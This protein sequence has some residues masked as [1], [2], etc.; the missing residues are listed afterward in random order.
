MNRGPYTGH[1]ALWWTALAGGILAVGWTTLQGVARSTWFVER[2]HEAVVGGI[3]A[4]TGGH[5]SIRELLLEEPLAFHVKGLEVR[6]GNHPDRPPLLQVPEASVRLGW[7]TVLGGQTVI[8]ELILDGLVLDVAV[9]PSDAPEPGLPLDGPDIASVIVRR[10][11]L[12]QGQVVWNGQPLPAEFAAS[13]LAVEV[14]FDPL[15]QLYTIELSLKDP[16]LGPQD[17]ALPPLGYAS[18]LARVGPDSAEIPEL[19]IRGRTVEVFAS[20]VIPDLQAPVAACSYSLRTTARALAGWL[21]LDLPAVAGS[22]Q[23]DGDLTW[24]FGTGGLTHMGAVVGDRLTLGWEGDPASFEARFEGDGSEFSLD[25][26]QGSLFGGRAE[27][28]GQLRGGWTSR[29]VAAEGRLEGVDLLRSATALGLGTVPWEGLVDAT[30]RLNGS[31][32]AGVTTDLDLAFRPLEE[33]TSSDPPLTGGGTLRHA[34]RDGSVTVEHLRIGSSAAMIEASG[35]VAGDGYAELE[36]QVDIGSRA[37]LEDLFGSLYPTARL[38]TLTP[39]GSYRYRGRMVGP[40]AEESRTS[41]VGELTVEDFLLGGERWESMWARGI[42]SARGLRIRDGFLAGG[43]G[44]LDV[45]GFF[46][47]DPDETMAVSATTVRMSAGKLARAGGFDLPIDGSLSMDLELSG[48]LARPVAEASVVLDD[49][50]FF[51]EQF[52][53]MD[54]EVA[55]GVDGWELRDG[56]LSRGESEILASAAA[57]VGERAIELHLRSEHWPIA[58]VGSLQEFAPGLEGDSSFELEGRGQVGESG[59]LGTLDL[60][61][62]WSIRDLHRDGIS[63]GHWEGRLHSARSRETL[64]LDLDAEVFGGTLRGQASLWQTEPP[65]YSGILQFRDLGVQDMGEFLGMPAADVG[66]RLGGQAEFDGVLGRAGGPN[67]DGTVDQFEVSVLRGDGNVLALSSPRPMRWGVRDGT[68]TLQSMQLAGQGADLS[69]KG[70][71]GLVGERG[72]DVSALGQLDTG[73]IERLVPGVSLDGL[74]TFALH[75]GNSLDEPAFQGSVEL[76]GITA[77]GSGLPVRLGDLRGKVEV[78]GRQARFEQLSA[79]SGGGS[80][81]LSGAAAYH[82]GELEYRLATRLEGVRLNIPAD[83][84]S[85]VDGQLTLAGAGDRS[86]LDGKLMI[87]RLS[88]PASI[89]FADFLQNL[90]RVRS[91]PAELGPLE[92]MQ[93][94]V[95][96]N[97]PPQLAVDTPLV[98]GAR[99]ILDL[100]VVGTASHPSVT[101]SIGIPSGEIRMLGTHYTITRGEIRFVNPLHTESVIDVELET[102]IRDVDIALVLSGPAQDLNVS[103]RSDPPLPFHDLVSLVAVG[104]EPTYDPS[105]ATQRRLEQHS[106]ERTGADALLSQALERPVSRRLQ[107]FFGVSRVKVD[108]QIGGLEANPGARISTEQQITDDITLIYSYDLSSAQQQAV[109]IEWNPN[110][111]WSFIVT[112]DQNGLVGSDVLFKVRLP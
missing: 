72:L 31:L 70:T 68:L 81:E 74:A 37:A 82:N 46:P 58:A 1:A 23:A 33:P 27:V 96:V 15:E 75:A 52:D 48:S 63:L 51:Q 67:V 34:A 77:Q 49:L 89:T 78:E 20:A 54:A 107:R 93:L 35:T 100:E 73:M 7:S 103:Y 69:V 39:D 41:L 44:R 57:H 85:V 5:V 6:S 101:G 50:S 105:V 91:G 2:V 98:R 97:S 61:G 87:S 79:V 42:V 108:P 9:G 99:A 22:L 64:N 4:A 84:S 13:E 10:I 24:E 65:R 95:A 60:T 12:R 43:G 59:R 104:K 90:G 47:M 14:A 28:T 45:R 88:T 92:G 18:L 76:L 21:G 94:N 36:V 38:P 53:R 110:R 71:V 80:V 111:T 102:R 40:L 62:Q 56:I 109:R 3:E 66:G 106:L 30:F 8:E 16:L 19:T 25:R 55:Y 11:Q 29:V 83:L 112:R 32:S 17:P 86:I 26:M